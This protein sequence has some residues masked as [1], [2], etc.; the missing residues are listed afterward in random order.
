MPSYCQTEANPGHTHNAQRPKNI[1]AV[2]WK[3]TYL[4]IL[5][6]TVGRHGW[7]PSQNYS[8][9]SGNLSE[10]IEQPISLQQSFSNVHQ[11]PLKCFIFPIWWRVKEARTHLDHVASPSLDTQ[12]HIPKI[13]SRLPPQKCMAVSC[14]ILESIQTPEKRPRS[15]ILSN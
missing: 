7:F 13:N 8:V 12:K 6:Q 15:W 9:C 2:H 4:L 1:F 5:I 14:Q 3:Y 10:S 11:S